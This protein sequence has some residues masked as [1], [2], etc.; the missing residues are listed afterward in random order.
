[1]GALGAVLGT[2]TMPDGPATSVPALQVR[3]V[4]EVQ[5]IADYEDCME[6]P[7]YL[8]WQAFFWWVEGNQILLK[9]PR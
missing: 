4:G 8:R 3:V 7:V 1:M 2:L 6:R 9:R 5:R